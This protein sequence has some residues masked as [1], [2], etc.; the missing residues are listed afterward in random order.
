MLFCSVA[1]A[2]ENQWRRFFEITAAAGIVANNNS[3]SMS[4]GSASNARGI[5]RRDGEYQHHR[6]AAYMKVASAV[7]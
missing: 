4:S 7:A 2:L 3:I 6:A 5:A 1:E